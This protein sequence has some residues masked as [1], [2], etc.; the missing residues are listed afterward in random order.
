MIPYKE[1]TIIGRM[2]RRLALAS[3]AAALMATQT[4]CPVSPG[5]PSPNLPAAGPPQVSTVVAAKQD[6][7]YTA[8]M[9]GT[10]KG[11]ETTDIYAKVGG[12]LEEI[13]VDIG[14]EVVK[15]DTLAVL[16]IP[17][18]DQELER[19][20]AVAESAR[21]IIKQALA[22]ITQADAHVQSS[23]AAIEEAETEMDEVE[24]NH[25]FR[26]AQL[27]RTTEL[28]NKKALLAKKLDEAKFNFEAATAALGTVAARIRTTKAN[29]IAANANVEKAKTDHASVV[30]KARV[31]ELDIEKAKTMV[32]YGTLYAPFDGVVTRRMFDPGAFIKPADGNSAALPLLTI[33]RINTVRII[34]HVP[35]KEVR[36]LNEGD[37]VV[38]DRINV[39][40]GTRIEGTVTRFSAALNDISRMLR[41]E[42]DLPN[43]DRKLRPGYF[44][45]VTIELAVFEDTPVVPSSAL[46]TIDDRSYVFVV[47]GTKCHLREVTTNYRD[48]VIV[49]IESG[50]EAGDQV[51]RTGV[52][53]LTDGQEVKPVPVKNE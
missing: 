35:M 20:E 33:S 27:E 39:L 26:A 15:G 28:V 19:L 32:G 5:M 38:F 30:A 52:G 24:A 11:E 23:Q 14:D 46:A 53:Q 51:V 12:F 3:V 16:S 8:V 17:E 37:K 48:G 10:V 2:K 25:R 18:M 45:Y 49:G 34:V 43:D 50:I 4:G 29:L 9:P 13:R 7:K 36:W 1:P 21:A 41:V 31:A 42:I 47:E 40:P 44:G 22:G 6:L